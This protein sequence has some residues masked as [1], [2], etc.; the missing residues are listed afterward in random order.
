MDVLC[1]LIVCG[2]EFKLDEIDG[3]AL[4]FYAANKHYKHVVKPLHNAGFDLN[5][6]DEQGKTVVF[7][8]NEYF[9]DALIEVVEIFIDARDHCG[10]TPLSANANFLRFR[11]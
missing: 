11:F 10:R 6:T 1:A 7:Y 5:I 2:A 4:L 9:L 8:G 3:K